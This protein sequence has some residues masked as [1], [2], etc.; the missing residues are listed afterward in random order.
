M[1]SEAATDNSGSKSGFDWKGLS[2]KAWVIVLAGILFPPM[3]MVLAWLKPGW[4]TRSRWIATG[5]MGLLLIGRLSSPEESQGPEQQQGE[6]VAA[7]PASE[8]RAPVDTPPHAK[9]G[10]TLTAEYLPFKQGARANYDLRLDQNTVF[11]F[12]WDFKPGNVIEITHRSASDGRGHHQFIN[13]PSGTYKYRKNR[14]FVELGDET[15]DVGFVWQPIV[16]IGAK[17][18]DTWES[19]KQHDV[20]HRYVVEEFSET[21]LTDPPRTSVEIS[22]HMTI[23]GKL[24]LITQWY[25]AKGVGITAKLV[26]VGVSHSVMELQGK[27]LGNKSLIEAERKFFQ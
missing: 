15:E 9:I 3:G 23:N 22:D 5:L 26:T 16:K 27:G 24:V 18:G 1:K 7:E 25:L 12:H 10:E 14:S 20:V 11:H 8:Q 17:L 19:E 6:K 21:G 13:R 4:S 2:Q